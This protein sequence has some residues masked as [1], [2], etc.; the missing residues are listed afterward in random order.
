MLV[1]FI[2]LHRFNIDAFTESAILIYISYIII[3]YFIIKTVII[4]L[5]IY[6]ISILSYDVVEILVNQRIL[7]HCVQCSLL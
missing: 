2:I 6:H 4:F 3:N 7:Y 1:N 5:D